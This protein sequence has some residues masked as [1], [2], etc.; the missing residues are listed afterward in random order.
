[1]VRRPLGRTGLALSPIGYGAFKI[2]RNQGV[3]YRDAYELPDAHAVERLLAGLAE[4]G[5]NYFDTAPAYGLSEERLGSF[6]SQRSDLVVSSK[7]GETFADNRSHYDFSAAAV[8]ASLERSL[9]RLGRDALDIVFVHAPANDLEVLETSDV[10]EVLQQAKQTGWVRCIGFSG[11]T[12]AAA[13]RA[14]D[15]ADVLMVEYHLEDRSHAEVI[16]EAAARGVG[17]VVKKGLAS[18]RLDPTAAIPWVLATPGVASLVVGS[19][20]LARMRMNLQLAVN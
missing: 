2:G 1:V 3:K 12:V 11:K 7:V 16:V 13:R 19:L 5:I 15:W 17:V 8:R 20:S 18:G 14:L 4:A 10:V 9:R 6:L